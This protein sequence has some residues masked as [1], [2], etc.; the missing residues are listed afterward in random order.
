[1]GFRHKGA[2]SDGPVGQKPL[3]GAGVLHPLNVPRMGF[4]DVVMKVRTLGLPLNRPKRRPLRAPEGNRRAQPDPG[5]LASG[6]G[7][8][9]GRRDSASSDPGRGGHRQAHLE[10][11]QGRAAD[12]LPPFPPALTGFAAG[13]SRRRPAPPRRREVVYPRAGPS[14]RTSCLDDLQDHPGAQPAV[15]GAGSPRWIRAGSSGGTSPLGEMDLAQWWQLHAR[16]KA[17]HLPAAA[18]REGRPGLPPAREGDPAQ[19]RQEMEVAGKRRVKALLVELGLQPEDVPG[20]PGQRAADPRRP[21]RRRRHDRG[22]DGNLGRHR[23]AMKCRKCG[24]AAAWRCGATTR[25]SANALP[26]VLP[27]AG[28]GRRQARNVQTRGAECWWRSRAARTPWRCGT[29]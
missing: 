18:R 21:A 29:C 19:P 4:Q 8:V 7:G 13:P 9:V 17:D 14:A 12:L 22:A 5:G 3:R 20:D 24:G 2:K 11:P 27:Q 10:A 25:P 15:D 28:R 23:A 1:M 6:R 16:Q 26:R